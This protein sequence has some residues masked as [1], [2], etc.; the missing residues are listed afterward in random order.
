M[1][2]VV[3][4]PDTGMCC[5]RASSL[6]CEL[7][8]SVAGVHT[9]LSGGQVRLKVGPMQTPLLAALARHL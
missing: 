8:C 4:G 3:T 9:A 5:W 1:Q 6:A 7:A 2:G